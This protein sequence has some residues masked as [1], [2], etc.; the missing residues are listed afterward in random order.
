MEQVKIRTYGHACFLLEADG[1]RTVI[2]PYADGKVPG[3][4]PL[5]LEAE[6]VYCS[7]GHDDHSYV[8][9]VTLCTPQRPAPYAL[10]EYVTPHDDRDGTLR[11]M[12]TVRIFDFGGLR[13][14]HLGD[15]GC[16]PEEKLLNRLRGVDCMMIPVGGHYTI[17]P[18]QARQ[19]IDAARPR[20]S[21]PMHYRSDDAGFGII[22]HLDEFTAQ[23]AHVNT[24]VNEVVL[25][26]N[27]PQQIL[28][29]QYKP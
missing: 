6:A 4:P 21:I 26:R 16:F 20:V 11:G 24:A 25:T 13:I 17:G 3:L 23:F 29:L 19:I 12:N 27:T 18:A 5:R 10:E 8:Q 9:A 22:A 2:D 7:H 15:I 28:I 1:Y 14:A